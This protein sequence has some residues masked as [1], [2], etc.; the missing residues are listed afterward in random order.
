MIS[1]LISSLQFSMMI[2]S[3]DHKGRASGYSQLV[4]AIITV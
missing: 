3:T 2:M 4:S 1:L